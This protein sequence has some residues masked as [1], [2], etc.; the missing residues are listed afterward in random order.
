MTYVY[1][2]GIVAFTV[3]VANNTAREIVKATSKVMKPADLDQL[4]G[5][6]SVEVEDVEWFVLS[7]MQKCMSRSLLSAEMTTERRFA[8]TAEQEKH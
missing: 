6:V 5:L 4:G 3:E 7:A 1:D 2:Q 8:Q